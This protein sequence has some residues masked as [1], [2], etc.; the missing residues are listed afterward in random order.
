MLKI[1]GYDGTLI[2]VLSF[3]GRI[4]SIADTIL[5]LLTQLWV[6]PLISLYACAYFAWIF[7]QDNEELKHKKKFAR[8]LSLPV[9]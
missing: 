5:D 3:L 7:I 2:A 4:Y 8:A 1:L 9:W 6:I